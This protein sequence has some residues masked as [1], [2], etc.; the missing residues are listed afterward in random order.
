MDR[1]F[2]D[3]HRGAK[4]P[5]RLFSKDVRK[6]KQAIDKAMDNGATPLHV[7]SKQGQMEA[8]R[9]LIEAGAAIDKA[10]DDGATPLYIASSIGHLEV[11]KTLLDGGADATLAAEDGRTPLEAA[12][13][14]NHPRVVSLLE[15]ALRK[16]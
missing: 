15:A 4:C 2:Y 9:L 14:M 16:R 10:L 11:V 12:K 8:V 7:A 13:E 5:D 1:E 3:D 6:I